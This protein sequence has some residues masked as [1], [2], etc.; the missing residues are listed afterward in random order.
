MRRSE[1]LRDRLN[2]PD[3]GRQNH[4]ASPPLRSDE[5]KADAEEI[6]AEGRR[7]PWEECSGY[8]P[9]LPEPAS[10]RDPTPETGIIKWKSLVPPRPED[11]PIRDLAISSNPGFPYKQLT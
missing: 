11:A 2:R 9:Y 3:G 4:T 6:A 7:E 1:K 8:R 10:I 5:R